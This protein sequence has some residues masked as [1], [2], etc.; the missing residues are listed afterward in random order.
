MRA[1]I[2]T[3]ASNCIFL[4]WGISDALSATALTLKTILF[5]LKVLVTCVMAISEGK[6]AT[7]GIQ[8]LACFTSVCV[9]LRKCFAELG[10]ESLD[11][12]LQRRNVRLSMAHCFL[13]W[14]EE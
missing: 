12:A 8:R 10:L 6:E 1:C 3:Y 4:L 11:C 14:L 7:V 2:G 13:L 5:V 9:T